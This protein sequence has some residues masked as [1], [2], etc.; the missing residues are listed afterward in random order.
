[1]VVGVGRGDALLARA[2][3]LAG[4]GRGRGRG[5]RRARRGGHGRRR[6]RG[7]GRRGGD[8]R[9][10]QAGYHALVECIVVVADVRRH[11]VAFSVASLLFKTCFISYTLLV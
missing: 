5:G 11:R 8:V 10:A 7:R 3:V 6:G 4:G 1:M 9:D 2:L